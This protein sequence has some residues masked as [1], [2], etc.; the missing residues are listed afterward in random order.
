LPDFVGVLEGTGPYLPRVSKSDLSLFDRIAYVGVDKFIDL[1]RTSVYGK[2][3]LAADMEYLVETGH[4]FDPLSH[5]PAGPLL[6]LIEKDRDLKG[7]DRAIR[8]A[9]KELARLWGEQSELSRSKTTVDVSGIE[10]T[11]Q[12]VYFTKGRLFAAL[13]RQRTGLDAC[14]MV[15]APPWRRWAQATRDDVVQLS[16]ARIPV[17]DD[18]TPWEAIFDF[19]RD[20]DATLRRERLRSWATS[21][22]QGDHSVAQA[23]QVLDHLIAEYEAA[24][25]LHRIKF[26][27]G[28]VE[29]V[30]VG[31]VSTVEELL[32][33]KWS[34]TAKRLFAIHKVNVERLEA[35]ADLHGGEVSFLVKARQELRA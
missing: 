33:L 23:E 4:V 7:M 8:R 20:P 17:P 32:T 27:H 2:P 25:R 9:S 12:E 6:A 14:A 18:A 10:H 30:V 16:L 21:T 11:L 5:Q 31:A 22:A 3:W 24:L 13:V 19:R 34:K 28:F 1:H 26:G 29:T 35:E 15:A